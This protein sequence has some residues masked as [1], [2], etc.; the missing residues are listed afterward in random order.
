MA[1]TSPGVEVTKIFDKYRPDVLAFSTTTSQFKHVAR[2]SRMLRAF[3]PDTYQICGGPHPTLAP[4][5]TLNGAPFDAVC[6]GEGEEVMVEVLEALESKRSPDIPGVMLRGGSGFV[7]PRPFIADLDSLPFLDREIFREY[8]PLE[9]YP[10]AVLTTRGC[11]F[12]CSYCSNHAL[13]KVSPGRYVRARSVAHVM[14]EVEALRKAFPKMD[15]LYMEDEA[16]GLN[17]E[18]WEG[19]LPA[20]G[21]TGL[22]FGCNYRIGACDPDFLWKM[23]KAH[24]CRVNIGIESGNEWLREHV[25]KRRYTNDQIRETYRIAKK[26]KMATK[27]YNLVGLPFETPKMFQET[28]DINRE[29]RP[30]FTILNAVFP[31]PGT[32]MRKVVDWLG[33][34][35]KG[36]EDEDGFRERTG[37]ALDFPSFPRGMVVWLVKNW[38]E[39]V[40]GK[41]NIEDYK[42]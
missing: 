35:K 8:I 31:Y 18:L 5:E 42:S 14:G 28:I 30:E 33:L 10:H 12:A 2:I 13:Q 24:F 23:A 27:S 26:N 21:K 6:I 3:S 41:K 25:L 20:L 9:R 39:I 34:I 7:S 36:A 16:V 17:K 38:G 29:V 1:Q 37:Y 4:E 11:P 40:R 22:K 19:L 32:E 15:Y